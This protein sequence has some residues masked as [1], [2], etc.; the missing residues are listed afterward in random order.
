[1]AQRDSEIAPASG[2]PIAFLHVTVIDVMGGQVRRNYTI[3]VK[4]GLIEEMGAAER[5]TLP[6]EARIVDGTDKF[7]IPGLW[8][9]HVHVGS[10][11]PL[12]PLYVANGVTGVRS[13]ADSRE[14]VNKFR[15]Q[16]AEGQIAGPRI[17]ATAGEIIDGPHEVWP[18]SVSA[19]SESEGKSAVDTVVSHGSEFAKVY[20][21]LPR[22]AYFGIAEQAKRKN[23]IFVGH[24]PMSVSA[25][26]ASDAG[27]KSV[28][29]LIGIPL[30]CSLK[31]AYLRQEVFEAERKAESAWPA[32]RAYRR[33]DSM[34]FYTYSPQTAD[35]LFSPRSYGRRT[36]PEEQSAST[37]P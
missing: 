31:E 27:Q 26:E 36:P 12:L 24:I 20:D 9:M 5:I 16:I 37:L 15:H 30:A 22:S 11:A 14:G 4:G 17:I 21:M 13:M 33:A 18:G 23:F 34:A 6:K 19:A 29:H 1:M 28:E 35:A 3:V 8:D 7:V 2:T 10:N 32:L 25:A